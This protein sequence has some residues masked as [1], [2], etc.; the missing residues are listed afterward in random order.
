[1][2]VSWSQKARAERETAI[3]Y[4]SRDAPFAALN[5]LNEIEQQTS[6]LPA[7]PEMGRIGR[8]KGTRELVISRTPFI[9]IYRIEGKR[10]EI[11]RFLHGAQQWPPETIV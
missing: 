1:M 2:I 9:A 3:D 7:Q 10:I 11:L 4:I 5:Q 8:T 6:L